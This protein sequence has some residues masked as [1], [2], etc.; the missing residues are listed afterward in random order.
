MLRTAPVAH[1]RVHELTWTL[2]AC[3]VLVQIAYPLTPLT[4]QIEVTVLPVVVF[5]A[6]MVVDVVRLDGLRYALR[7]LAVACGGGLVAEAVGQATG[8]P[9]GAYAYTGTL[10]PELFAV[11]VVVPLAWMMMAWP[12]LVVGRTLGRSTPGVIAV[13][14]VALAAWD[15][16]LDPQMVAAGHWRWLDPGPSLP[17][18]PGV[19]LT[20]YGGWLL[21]S[22]ADRG[23]AALRVA[24][25]GPRAT[26]VRPGDRALPVGVLLLGARPPGLLR[27]P[28]LG[29]GRRPPDGRRRRAVRL[30][31]R[32]AR[33]GA[34]VA[35]GQA[36]R[37]AA[38]TTA[39][40]AQ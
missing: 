39:S 37:L 13:G 14:T 33:R 22:R 23:R 1:A 24:R 4:E 30:R 12:A 20:N 28:G 8:V 25:T 38:S 15:V 21:V 11:P 27:A 40:T 34:A 16:F 3:A 36:R 29:A 9:F 18:V 2:V 5:C 31:G 32:Q 6:A 10:G 26:P 19:P 7:L 17:L 35:G